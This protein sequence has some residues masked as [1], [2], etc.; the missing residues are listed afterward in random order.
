M[1]KSIFKSLVWL[2][3]LVFIIFKEGQINNFINILVGFIAIYLVT[4]SIMP[5]KFDTIFQNIGRLEFIIDLFV[6]TVFAVTFFMFGGYIIGSL[7]LLGIFLVLNKA[8]N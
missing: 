7:L 2:L 3:P 6:L 8:F 1:L 5:F 4:I